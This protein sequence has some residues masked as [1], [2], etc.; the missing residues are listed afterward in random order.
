MISF[1]RDRLFRQTWHPSF[2]ELLLH[3][4]GE[5]GPKMDRVGAHT[6]NC[7]SCRLRLEKIDRAISEYMEARNASFA[8]PPTFPTQVS[9]NF[10]ARLDRL[11]AECGSPSFFLSL[12]RQYTHGL[13]AQRTSPRLAIFL[14][15]LC[16]MVVVLVRLNL[17]QPV[18]AKEVLLQVRQAEARQMMQVAAPVIY[19]KLQ[20]RR[21]SGSRLET[22]TWEIWN[23]TGNNRVRQR[24][25]DAT[26]EVHG[27]LPLPIGSASDRML[28][29]PLVGE[30][31]EM[32]RSHRA[33]LGRPLSSTN[34]EVW[35]DSIRQESEEVLEGR[36]LN[37]DPATILRVSGQ[38]PFPPGAI[39]GAEFTVRA[40]D[41]HPVGQ[42][43][44][45]QKHEEVV[46][47]S[48]GEVAFEVMALSAVPSSI[49]AE[50]APARARTLETAVRRLMPVPVHSDLWAG[51]ADLLPSEADL[52]AAEV[53]ARY[54][55]HSVRACIGRPIAVR[56]GIGR[57]E[58]EGVVDTKE[59]KAEVLLA[60]RGI[61]R[62]AAEIRSVAEVAGI[63]R[64]E[65]IPAPLD[66]PPVGDA[67]KPKL[68]A[69]D[70]LRRYFGAGKCAGRPS[71]TQSAC[72][73]EEIASLSREALAHSEGAQAHAWALRR[74]VEW[75]PFLER[76]E[77][78]TATRRLLEI[79]VRDHMDALRNELEQSHAQLKPILSA[80]L[81]GESS[82]KENQPIEMQ[83]RRGDW[84]TE[85]LLGL[86]T[87][88]ED[89]VNLTLGT[90]AE[91]NRPVGQ[92]EQA[93]KDLLSELEGLNG[94]FPA[95]EA[96]IA[97]ELSGFPKT[98]IFSERQEWK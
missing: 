48:L 43:L 71:D 20:L 76:D 47:Y 42:R 15:S 39:V 97:T 7:W 44:L 3:L 19:E 11:E 16:L 55:L 13:F 21:A 4:D 49:F 96:D 1:W 74:L 80:L 58:V 92:P 82:R 51:D 32:F 53:E 22:A 81:G 87:G 59:R 72:V 9:R 27:V 12:V 33:D 91:T 35:R 73:Q 5:S 26:G 89:V 85:S 36:L 34:Y 14:A 67:P 75:G 60:L 62:V 6:K 18:S 40:A 84:V 30:L 29:L 69:E 88:V 10:A 68:P 57:I 31:G 66:E 83:D 2:E 94:G 24:L 28:T 90:F 98:R 63:P 77:L 50:R 17:P 45:V 64:G 52:T 8:G 95:L 23:D 54:A 79:M 61:P 78:R 93:M 65:G 56:V 41:W 86:C 70:L 25:Q 46:D 37:G 38:G